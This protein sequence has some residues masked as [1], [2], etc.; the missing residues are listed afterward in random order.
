LHL[1][2]AVVGFLALLAIGAAP[3]AFEP[4]RTFTAAEVLPPE[5]RKGPHHSIADP[6]TLDGFYL[7]FPLK[8]PYGDLKVQGQTLLRTRVAEAGALARLAE[9]SKTEVFVKAAG[10][11]VLNVGKGVASAVH[12]PEATVK[13]IGGGVKRF[14]VNLGRKAKRTADSATKDDKKPEAPPDESKDKAL[15]AAGGAANSVFGVNS[16]ARRWAQKLGVDPYSSNPMLHK[17][18]VDV[19][20]IDAG[21]SI[22]T[23]VVLPVPPVVSG[24]ATVGNLVWAK[25]P[26]EVRKTNE[27]RLGELGVAKAVASRY[28]VN[29]NYTLTSQTRFIGA[30]HAVKVKGCADYVDAA[31]EAADEREALFFVESAELLAAAHKAAPVSAILEDSRAL[32][33]KTGTTAVALLPVDWFHWTEALQ[34]ASTELSARARQELGAAALEARLT[35]ATS[36]G[37]REGLKAAGWVVKERAA[38]GLAATPAG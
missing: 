9:V 24:T 38:D 27:A 5:L 25:D 6:I 21:G 29:G 35:G 37:A 20:R 33:A 18:L 15:D 12:D 26:E 22:I 11:A 2:T 23:K 28:L 30:L 1:R 8:S 31:S 16:A 17:A 19:G 7:E 36:P 4:D 3:S 34:K 13:G 14:G 32:V 10:G